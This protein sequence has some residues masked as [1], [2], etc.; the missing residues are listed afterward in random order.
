MR[1]GLHSFS[2]GPSLE[3]QLKVAVDAEE[4]GFDSFWYG[5]IFGHERRRS[6]SS[7]EPPWRRPTPGTR[8][9]RRRRP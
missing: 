8:S 2:A 6:A 7:W 1:I 5:H 3:E 4:A 9:S